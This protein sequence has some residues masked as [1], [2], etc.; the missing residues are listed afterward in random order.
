MENTVTKGKYTIKIENFEGPLDLLYHL[1]GKKK[2]DIYD[3]K[4]EEIADQYLEFLSKM[5]K[6]DLEIASE[7]LVIAATLINIKSRLLVPSKVKEQE[8][9]GVLDPKEEL[10]LKVLH[11]KKYKEFSVK[12]HER[13]A[14]WEQCLFKDKEAIEFDFEQNVLDIEPNIL[15]SVY[16][17]M[18]KKNKAKKNQKSQKDMVKIIQYEKVSL[19]SKI[20]EVVSFLINRPK[21]LFSEIFLGKNKTRLEI[22]TGF[23][24]IL[25]LAK[26]RKI[27]IY[28]DGNFADISINKVEAMGN[29]EEEE[30]NIG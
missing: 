9:D 1:I 26:S 12:L 8:E 15:K 24:A 20:R 17:A 21:T 22:I 25:E 29:I 2:V 4:I 3:V 11:Y 6:L 27:D 18:L 19:K 28:Q 30:K 5:Q 13:Q 10:L 7:F 23:L 14:H 16:T